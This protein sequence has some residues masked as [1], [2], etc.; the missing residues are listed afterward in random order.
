MSTEYFQPETDIADRIAALAFDPMRP[1]ILCDADEVLIDF[2]TPLTR[3]LDR[4]GYRLDLKSFGLA[5]NISRRSDGAAIEGEE[6]RALIAAYFDDEIDRATPVDGAVQAIGDLLRIAQIV[7]VTNVPHRLRARRES[8]LAAAG[9]NLPV[10]SNSGGKGPL[11]RHL[12]ERHGG[13]VAFIDDLPPHHA[14]VAAHAG[15]VHRIHFVGNPDL[16]RLLDKAPDAH[17]RLDRWSE[18][19]S[20]LLNHFGIDAPC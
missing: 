16:G 7:V 12:A 15:N 19:R 14:S 6:I 9:L 17:V 20:H 4:R 18:C 2:A 1:L 5:G 3:F 8:A 13:R 11:I 10:L